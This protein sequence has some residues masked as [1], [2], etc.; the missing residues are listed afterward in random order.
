[1]PSKARA[2]FDSNAQDI[3]RLIGIHADIGGK[4][5]GRRHGLEVLNK[6]AIVLITAFWEA[7][8]EDIAAEGLAHIVKHSKSSDALPTELK[9][10]LSK[11]LKSQ[12]NDLE[13]WKLSDDGWRLYLQSHFDELKESRDRKLNTPKSAQIDQLFLDAVGI[14]KIS[15]SWKWGRSVTA[16]RSREKLDKFVSLRG[17]IAHRG[18]HETSVTKANVEDYFDFIKKIVARTGG[19]VNSHVLKITGKPLWTR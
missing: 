12:N 18:Q 15:D 9:K 7:Y 13:F 6:S 17:S 2:S 10:I 16:K 8:C 1:M 5:R 11:K 3:E 14:E 19:Q 4:G